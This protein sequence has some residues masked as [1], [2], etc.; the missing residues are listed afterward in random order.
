V[1]ARVTICFY[2]LMAEITNEERPEHLREGPRPGR[3]RTSTASRFTM[4]CE[5]ALSAKKRLLLPP[6]FLRRPVFRRQPVL[7]DYFLRRK[8][9]R[10]SG[11]RKSSS[12][13]RS[14]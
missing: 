12:R 7:R 2:T 14:S 10:R 8:R 5:R 9:R 4:C 1:Q 11:R 6:F 13:G 3:Y